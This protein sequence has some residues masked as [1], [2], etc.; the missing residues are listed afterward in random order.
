ME[1][2]RHTQQLL[3]ADRCGT[4]NKQGYTTVPSKNQGAEE[5]KQ[6]FFLGNWAIERTFV[7]L[8]SIFIVKVKIYFFFE[9]RS[10]MLKPTIQR[11]IVQKN[12]K[13]YIFYFLNLLLFFSLFLRGKKQCGHQRAVNDDIA[14]K[15]FGLFFFPLYTPS[16]T[17]RLVSSHFLSLSASSC[18]Q[19]FLWCSY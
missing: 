4:G 2:D 7:V 16:Q 17:I 12:P 1:D 5:M 11:N 14:S 15:T 19:P 18:S 10:K 3:S 8:N 9:Q 13:Q 6:D